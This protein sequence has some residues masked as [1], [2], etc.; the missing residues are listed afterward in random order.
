MSVAEPAAATLVASIWIA[1]KYE[2]NNN[3]LWMSWELGFFV[4]Q[5]FD[6]NVVIVVVSVFLSV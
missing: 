2:E 3:A 5:K 1:A 4:V 6:D